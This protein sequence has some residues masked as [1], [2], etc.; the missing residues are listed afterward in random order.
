MAPVRF[1]L[2]QQPAMVINNTQSPN[3]LGATNNATATPSNTARSTANKPQ[4]Q[5]VEFETTFN[6]IP[7]Q[8]N[9]STNQSNAMNVTAPSAANNSNMNCG[10]VASDGEQYLAP[11][12][13]SESGG[14]FNVTPNTAIQYRQ[15]FHSNQ[16]YATTYSIQPTHANT[17]NLP[18][19]FDLQ[20]M[21]NLR[22]YQMNPQN[23]HNLVQ[24][25]RINLQEKQA[26]LLNDFV[27]SFTDNYE[28]TSQTQPQQQSQQ[29]QTLQQP[30]QQMYQ[31]TSQMSTNTS[32]DS[33]STSTSMNKTMAPRT[34]A[35]RKMVSETSMNASPASSLGDKSSAAKSNRVTRSSNRTTRAQQF[36]TEQK[37]PQ[38]NHQK[39]TKSIAHHQTHHHPSHH[40]SAKGSVHGHTPRKTNRHK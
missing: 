14:G 4:Q 10:I 2:V 29:S 40:K 15:T 8:Q 22:N 23:Y 21:F 24:N 36:S 31:T 26:I 28:H 34:K 30:P 17:S 3:V 12:L 32:V 39:S 35:A 6:I 13:S 11:T 7:P 9:I 38:L 19:N 5:H 1:N 16:P 18:A 33:K 37:S 25:S 27:H 20:N